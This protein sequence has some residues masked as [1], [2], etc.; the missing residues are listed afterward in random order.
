MQDLIVHQRNMYAL[1]NKSLT[2]ESCL[3]LLKSSPDMSLMITS[4][5]AFQFFDK[6]THQ[7]WITLSNQVT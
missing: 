2:E 6:I 7:G 3:F 5:T 4:R 1:L